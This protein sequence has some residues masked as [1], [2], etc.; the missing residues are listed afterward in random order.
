[1]AA[2]TVIPPTALE[3]LIGEE[4]GAVL[5]V[6]ATS[7]F[8]SPL[9]ARGDRLTVIDKDPAALREI[10]REHPEIQTV[11]AGSEHLPFDPSY[12][13]AVL[14]VQNFHTLAPGLA[15]GE[16]AR[17]LRPEGRAGVVYLT[18]DDSVP[19]VKKLKLIV[20]SRLPSA[21]TADSGAGSVAAFRESSFFC[22]VEQ[23]GY[24]LWVPCSRTALQE[25][26]AGA[27][28]AKSLSDG[29]LAAMLEEIGQLYDHYARVPDPMQL[30]YQISCWRGWVD[31]SSALGGLTLPE[32][33]L[34]ISL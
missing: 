20:Q 32:D 31:P 21:M 18:R 1:M 27:E 4:P 16:W 7:G 23:V 19:W 30:P 34:S 28:G 14:A 11:V 33:G 26:A 12:F 5:L 6:G 13:Q 8:L 15:L 22:R 29:S 17:V 9:L 25:N 10:A 24:R 3:W 2:A